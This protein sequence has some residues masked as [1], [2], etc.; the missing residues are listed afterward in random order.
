ALERAAGAPAEWEILLTLAKALMGL[1]DATLDAADDVVARELVRRELAD[2]GAARRG[3]G[4][5]DGLPLDVDAAMA[6]LGGRRGPDRLVDFLLRVGPY[7][8]RLGAA[9]G[10]LTLD[11]LLA[12][13]HGLDL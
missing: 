13:P 12:S 11:A 8:D 1:G 4:A 2:A 3:D 6:A 9:P 5:A 7:G 10:G